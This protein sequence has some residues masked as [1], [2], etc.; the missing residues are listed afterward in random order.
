MKLDAFHIFY[1]EI[2]AVQ[3]SKKQISDFVDPPSPSEEDGKFD[4]HWSDF[5]YDDTPIDRCKLE[6]DAIDEK[7]FQ[8][9]KTLNN[10][11]Y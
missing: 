11:K 7:P 4:D 2:E 10:G 5:D 6:A 9:N 8:E 3:G 1:I